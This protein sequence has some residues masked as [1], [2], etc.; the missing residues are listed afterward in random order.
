MIKVTP[1]QSTFLG[2]P[3]PERGK[4]TS[5][6]FWEDAEDAAQDAMINATSP[7]YSAACT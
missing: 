2:L 3:A 1:T 5:R 7:V 6:P 4:A